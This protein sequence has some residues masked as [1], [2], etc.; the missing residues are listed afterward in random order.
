MYGTRSSP[1]A[2]CEIWVTWPSVDINGIN[3]KLVVS[4]GGGDDSLNAMI[5]RMI[6]IGGAWPTMSSSSVK[7]LLDSQLSRMNRQTFS[8][9]HF[10]GSGSTVML[11]GT[12]RSA[13]RCHSA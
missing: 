4:G 2:P 12:S 13:D 6:T 10:A 3:R 5:G 1:G 9:G 7:T 11:A 8:S